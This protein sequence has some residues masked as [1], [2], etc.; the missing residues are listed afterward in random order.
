MQIWNFGQLTDLMHNRPCTCARIRWSIRR[1]VIGRRAKVMGDTWK[2]V[3]LLGLCWVVAVQRAD[4]HRIGRICGNIAC[5]AVS[6]QHAAEKESMVRKV[7][8]RFRAMK[9]Q[10]DVCASIDIKSP[11]RIRT[12]DACRCV[13]FDKYSL[14]QQQHL[15]VC[16]FHQLRLFFE[17]IILVF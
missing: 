17:L 11:Q 7:C 10:V 13:R 14:G 4:W 6:A 2:D 12:N 15:L 8:A 9:L 1:S 3:P 5:R 16:I